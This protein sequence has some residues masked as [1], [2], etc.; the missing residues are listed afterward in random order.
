MMSEN[1]QQ[2]LNLNAE[3]NGVVV[4]ID[5]LERKRLHRNSD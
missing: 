5:R 2:P 4:Q 1:P 3:R